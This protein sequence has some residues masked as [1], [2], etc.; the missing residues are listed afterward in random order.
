[1]RRLLSPYL[2]TLIIDFVLLGG[3]Y[4][5]FFFFVG[6][7][8]IWAPLLSVGHT[9][10]LAL[11]K[12]YRSNLKFLNLMGLRSL[13][14]VSTAFCV[15]IFAITQ[16]HLRELALLVL[17]QNTLTL[18]HRLFWYFRFNP[19]SR[20][21][22][23]GLTPVI[24]YGAGTVTHHLLQDLSTE[25]LLG[26]YQIAAIVDNDE[27]KVG[28][29]LGPYRVYSGKEIT[30][31]AK[32]FRAS[33]VWFTMP[34]SPAFLKQVMDELA[35]FSI[36]YKVIPRKLH[37]L[38]PDMRNLRI[39]DLI[40]RPEIRLDE[41]GVR[42]TLSGK[43]ILV[44]GAAGSIGSELSRQIWAM[45]PARLT[46]VDQWEQGVYN[47]EQEFRGENIFCAI[48]DVRNERRLRDII[49]TEK[50]EIIFHAAAYKH[51]PLMETNHLQAIDTN[52]FGAW[53]LLSAAKSYCESLEGDSHLSIVNISTDKAVSPENIMGLTKRIVELLMHN[54]SS[55]RLRTTSVRFGNV[56]GSSGSVVPLF[57]Q[58]IA[59]GGP[60]TVTHPEMERFFMTIPEAV[61]LVLQAASLKNEDGILA[62]DMGKPVRIE[63]LAERLI[64]LAGKKPR[65]EVQIVYSGI[66]PGEKLKE[67]LFW[68]K[69]SVQTALPLIFRSPGDLKRM[70]AEAFIALLKVALDEN[71]SLSWYKDFFGKYI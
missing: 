13:L 5:F 22:K 12:I 16:E 15:V 2:I 53:H 44:T 57:W 43:R 68:E 14:L 37:E 31:L 69:N 45:A 9:F 7:D 60:V 3:A 64:L 34:T 6:S 29:H 63:E 30:R 70:D 42:Q 54:M 23:Q 17:A 49:I 46:L 32:K 10:A 21:K 11:L 41:S 36:A 59:R 20:L 38:V 58:Q 35:E 1:M 28:G 71:R 24:I 56:L 33:E 47:L 48:A 26:R 55:A 39:E 27:E 62:L 25:D 8:Y 51:V 52:I 19:E 67:E 18:L 65:S 40:R 4:A 66:R 50:P 61:R